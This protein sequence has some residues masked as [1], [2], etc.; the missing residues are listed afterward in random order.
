ML[1]EAEAMYQRVLTRKEKMLGPEHAS[2]LDIVNNL[3][4]LYRN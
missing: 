3:G 2:A 4:I 1:A